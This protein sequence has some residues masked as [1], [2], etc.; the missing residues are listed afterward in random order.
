MRTVD[1]SKNCKEA[2]EGSIDG[3]RV[4]ERPAKP[5]WLAVRLSPLPSKLN[6]PTF[7]ARTLS[8]TLHC[9]IILFCFCCVFDCL[10]YRLVLSVTCCDLRLLSLV[11]PPKQ[12]TFSLGDERRVLFT[13]TPTVQTSPVLD[14]LL[15]LIDDPADTSMSASK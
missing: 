15:H 4:F 8:H 7:S 2:E 14:P 12:T 9:A 10:G 6:V 1:Q 5:D 13:T 3:C 11:E